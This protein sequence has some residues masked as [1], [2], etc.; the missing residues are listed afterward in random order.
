[1]RHAVLVALAILAS[2]FLAEPALAGTGTFKDGKFNFCVSVRFNATPAQ[3]T[4]IQ[5]R[6]QRAN[7]F[8]ADATDGQ[9]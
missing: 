2:A 8:L 5:Q 1:V 7:Q 3:L 9:H 4:A 6:F